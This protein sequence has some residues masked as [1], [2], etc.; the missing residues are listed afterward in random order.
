MTSSQPEGP[1]VPAAAAAD[2]EQQLRQEIDQTRQ[3]LG[4]TV[5]ALAGKADVKARAQAWKARLAGQVKAQAARTRAVAAERAGTVRSQLA[6]TTTRDRQQAT[7][8]AIVT[9]AAGYL[10]TRIWRKR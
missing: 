5:E 7:A 10:V 8:A 3:Q 9:L 6:D 4:D 1:A 2:A